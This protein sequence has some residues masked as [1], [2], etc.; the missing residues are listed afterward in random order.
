[1]QCREHF[2]RFYEAAPSDT[3]GGKLIPGTVISKAAKVK[4]G[5]EL[6]RD[7]YVPPKATAPSF[8]VLTFDNVI[9]SSLQRSPVLAAMPEIGVDRVYCDKSIE[10]EATNWRDANKKALL[11]LQ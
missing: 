11:D 7:D 4:F 8:P 6:I 10:T 3:E 2:R 1:V 5:E 9:V